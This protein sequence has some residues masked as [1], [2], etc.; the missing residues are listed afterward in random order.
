MVEALS[1]N[2]FVGDILKD[3]GGSRANYLAAVKLYH[4][5]RVAR[6]SLEIRRLANEVFLSIKANVSTTETPKA[7]EATEKRS[8]KISESP[9]PKM[10]AEERMRQARSKARRSRASSGLHKQ[11]SKAGASTSQKTVV[12][13][14]VDTVLETSKAESE[15]FEAEFIAA[16]KHLQ[17]GLL[18]QALLEFRRLSVKARHDTRLK[19]YIYV[20]K[21]RVQLKKQD[22]ESALKEI[23]KAEEI[24][25]DHSVVLETQEMIKI[26]KKRGGFFSRFL[27]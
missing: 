11:V 27:K 13:S 19:I 12:K 22:F 5:N 14:C 24:D 7:S 25:E 26:E 23:K 15:H 2:A 9:A 4:P 1:K 8:K 6:R 17:E 16:K 10:T 18:E 20:A 21:S 3:H